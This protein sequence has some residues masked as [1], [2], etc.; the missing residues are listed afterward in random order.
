MKKKR[1]Q[2]VLVAA[3]AMAGM[4]RA[5]E[6]KVYRDG[7]AWVEETTGSLP[8]QRNLRLTTNFGSVHIQGGTANNVTYTV[9][10]RVYTS[11]EQEARRA[12]ELIHISASTQ[13]DTVN[14]RGQGPSN[15]GRGRSYSAD[16]D[17]HTPKEL[18]VYARTGGGNLAVNAI[19]GA[20]QA[21]TGG[22]NVSLDDVGGAIDASSGGGSVDVGTAGA[23]VKLETGGG[24]I[25]LRSAGGIVHAES[26]GGAIRVDSG[27]QNIVLVTGGGPIAVSSCGG[28][29]TAETG[30]GNIT[31]GNVGGKA[32]LKTGGG[33]IKLT[34]ANGPVQ[35]ES[36]GGSVE[37][38]KLM[39]G[40]QV[41]TG[42]GQ[43]T[44]EFIG[45][46]ANF[47]AS[48]L[49]TAAGDIRVYLPEDLPVT[50]QAAI[51]MASG[52]RIHSEFPSLQISSEGPGWAK[53]TYCQGNIN[54]GGKVL[55]IHT[56]T[57]N[58][59][60]LKRTVSVSDRNPR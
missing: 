24:N 58:I 19:S 22:G 56:S 52:Q 60:L 44:A 15:Y 37:L 50:V 59:E 25:N 33:A 21:E 34:S 27:K 20:V 30:G 48:R 13:G 4:A 26:G 55:H 23:E 49:E 47:T 40:A 3:L 29:L 36:G 16:F 6:A 54:G 31:A 35:A 43:I 12:F 18:D 5:Q 53:E 38:Y 1:I 2:I 8:A 51:D 17:I 32:T 45:Q 9:K 39:R 14:L 57:G 7:E 11:S 41:A 10:K 42:G 28:D 46:G